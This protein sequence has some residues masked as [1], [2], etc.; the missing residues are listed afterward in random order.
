[1]NYKLKHLA[2]YCTKPANELEFEAVKMAAELGGVAIELEYHRSE[3]LF[4]S[5]EYQEMD[6]A[7]SA[8]IEENLDEFDIIPALDFIKKL[9]MTEEE[10]EKLEDDR[11]EFNGG[12]YGVM[13]YF[14]PDHKT[15]F[16]RN[17]HYFKTNEDGTE[18]TLHKRD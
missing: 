15:M 4:Y 11:V 6:S 17:G 7:Q 14:S 2:K 16:V 9:R 1:M 12:E 18:V 10:A 13:Y 3:Y 8:Y 5:L